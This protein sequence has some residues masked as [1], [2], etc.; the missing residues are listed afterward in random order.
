MDATA[1]NFISGLI[2]VILGIAL[3]RFVNSRYSE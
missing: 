3:I 1:V 2:A